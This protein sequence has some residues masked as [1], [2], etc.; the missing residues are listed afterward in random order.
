MYTKNVKNVEIV[1]FW[2]ERFIG[3]FITHEFYYFMKRRG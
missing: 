2:L 1:N 3:V